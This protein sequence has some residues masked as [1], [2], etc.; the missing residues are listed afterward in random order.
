MIVVTARG[1]TRALFFSQVAAGNASTLALITLC[2]DS[3]GRRVFT[4]SSDTPQLMARMLQIFT[5]KTNDLE[6]GS[7]LRSI[8]ELVELSF[9]SD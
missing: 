1:V 9:G 5:V 7:G 2:M 6:C 4:A 8:S 3:E